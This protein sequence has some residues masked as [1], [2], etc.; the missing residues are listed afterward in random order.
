VFAANHQLLQEMYVVRIK[1]KS[2]MQDSWDIFEMVRAV[3]GANDPLT[4]IQPSQ[5]ENPCPI[6]G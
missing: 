3:P 1:E 4:L 6:A 5:Q 2:R